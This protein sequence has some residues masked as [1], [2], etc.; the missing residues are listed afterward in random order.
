MRQG[1]ICIISP[2]LFNVYMDGVMKEVKMGMGKRRMRFQEEGRE[3]RLPGFLYAD[4]LVLCGELEEDMRMMVG[5]FSEVCGGRALKV[6]MGRRG[7]SVRF[8]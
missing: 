8:A 1:C 2:W 5:C 3:W 4:D 6:K 7:W